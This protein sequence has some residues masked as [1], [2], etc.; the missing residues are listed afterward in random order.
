MY[1][2][3]T[4]GTFS[5]TVDEPQHLA[6]G[7][8]WWAG[9]RAV[10]RLPGYAHIAE[11]P[12]LAHAVVG[13]VPF[14]AGLRAQPPREVLYAGAGYPSNLTR[15]RVGV[16]PFLALAI[17]L[18]WAIARR[19]F[20]GPSA[21]AAAVALG[22]VPAVLG[23][24]GLATTDVVFLA[25][26]LLAALA[27][28]RWLDAASPTRWHALGAGAAFGL[29]FATKLSALALL[30][31]AALL[32]LQRRAAR[33]LV[34]GAAPAWPLRGAAI[35]VASAAAAGALVVWAAYGF[36]FGRAAVAAGPA[37][38][39]QLADRCLATPGLARRLAGAAGGVPMPAPE[40]YVGWLSLCGHNAAGR[41][42]AYLLGQLSQDGFPL[43]FPVALAVKTPLPFAALAVVGLIVAARGREDRR[44][45]A[46][47]PALIALVLLML[48]LPARINIGV[49]HVL[50]ILPLLAIY[51]G[52]GAVALWRAGRRRGLARAAAV[53]LGGWLLATPARAAPD[54]LAWFNG[55]AGRHP[56]KVLLDSDLDWGQDLLRLERVA[57]EL[58]IPRLTLAYFGPADLCR[59]RLPPGR[60]LRPHERA[61]GWI[62]V[63]EMYRKGVVGFF[64]R[65]G[66]YCDPGQL[67]REAQPDPQQLAWLDAYVPVAR[68]GKSIRL[69]Y[70][71]EGAVTP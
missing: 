21:V 69:Y 44:W 13:A 59:H 27:L 29:A 4:Y 36:S 47:A 33:R 65:N 37:L 24:A 22:A 19:L 62:A 51:A 52:A 63:S 68:V 2:A 39:D 67:T 16:L 15:A 34:A 55:L 17:V 25:T 14:A 70:I 7:L 40:L 5:A 42:T 66:D 1:V 43:F 26:F 41:S 61:T 57:A 9:N 11:N 18:T 31:A 35:A 50:P 49:R 23:H 32:V 53:V 20:D 45:L 56:E 30:P 64:Y 38:F 8:G 46:L 58:R 54:H 28:L 71:P 60:W 6:A 3:S 10:W 12:P 48:N